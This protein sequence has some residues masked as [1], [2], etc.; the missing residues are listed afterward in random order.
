MRRDECPGGEQIQPKQLEEDSGAQSWLDL[1]GE[2]SPQG[3]REKG[4]VYEAQIKGEA[5]Q[6]KEG[7]KKPLPDKT[8]ISCVVIIEPSPWA[9]R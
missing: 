3:G 7:K 9:W 2:K 6:G 4:A 5:G 1:P 8:R